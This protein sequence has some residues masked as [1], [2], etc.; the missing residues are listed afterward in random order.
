LIKNLPPSL[1]INALTDV[2]NIIPRKVIWR[3]TSGGTKGRSLSY[4]K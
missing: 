2:E 1:Y 3:C 4:A